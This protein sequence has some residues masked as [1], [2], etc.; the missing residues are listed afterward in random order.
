MGE[1]AGR[2]WILDC[3]G[4]IWLADQAI[5]GSSEAVARLRHEGIRV[6]FLTNNSYPK[7]A[8][9]LE[10][11]EKMGMPTEASD[12]ISSPMAAAK[13]LER[14]ENALVLGGPGV[15]EALDGEGVR[16]FEPGAVPKGTKVDAVVVGFD[17]KFDFG[18]L[19]AATT[20]LRSGARLIGT[21]DDATFPAPEGL[22]PGA[23]SFL[24]A[25][26]T[27]G[28][29]KP[30]IAGKPYAPVADLVRASIG[31]VERVVGDRPSTDGRFAAELGVAFGL[32][33][34]GVTPPDHG[35]IEPEPDAEADD[36][37]TLVEH[38]LGAD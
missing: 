5:P 10:K 7:V 32:V 20:A 8:S 15:I 2:T 9:H 25:V 29:A 6:V 19:A 13:M 34:S 36:L 24:A 14:G 21:N 3:D 31:T 33:L 17:L 1:S 18:R 12:L 30:Q 37:A 11:L 27:A 35:P 38:L 26:S 28:G 22:W 23:G 16:T 4:V